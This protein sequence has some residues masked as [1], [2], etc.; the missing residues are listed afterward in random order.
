MQK[1]FYMF[2]DDIVLL[3]RGELRAFKVLHHEV[4]DIPGP[5]VA[6][7]SMRVAMDLDSGVI[8]KIHRHKDGRVAKY[9]RYVK[10][11]AATQIDR[12]KCRAFFENPIVA[13][14]LYKRQAPKGRGKQGL[15]TKRPDVEQIAKPLFD[16]LQGQCYKDDKQITKVSITKTVNQTGEPHSVILLLQYLEDQRI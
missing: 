15:N 12:K 1:G 11:T 16:A 3:H 6:K 9:E 8:P 14:I 7:Q 10:E 4:I 5:L 13:T 2:K